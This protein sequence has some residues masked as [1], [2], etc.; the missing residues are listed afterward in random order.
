M[1]ATYTRNEAKSG[2]EIRFPARPDS[3]TLA[4]I[5]SHGFSWSRRQKLWYAKE[6]PD[7]LALCQSITASETSPAPARPQRTRRVIS[8]QFASGAHAYQNSRGRCEDAPCCGC[9]S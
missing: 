8:M 3:D 2:L 9:C 5:K 6:S 1:K 7:R 4:R